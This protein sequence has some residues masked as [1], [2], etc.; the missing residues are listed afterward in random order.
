MGNSYCSKTEFLTQTKVNQEMRRN[1]AANWG[2]RGRNGMEHRHPFG[3]EQ[4]AWRKKRFCWLKKV[5]EELTWLCLSPS[6]T[7]TRTPHA[8]TNEHTL[9]VRY[10][11]R[12]GNM[13]DNWNK[14][15]ELK[16][17]SLCFLPLCTH[18]F[19]LTKVSYHCNGWRKR[20]KAKKEEKLGSL[21]KGGKI[22]GKWPK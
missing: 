21:K 11:L 6:K 10:G 22:R 14:V 4:M 16:E 18:Q 20:E 5:K 12:E 13:T 15:R 2:V 8:R 9:A 19:A 1:D 17:S 3:S 7:P